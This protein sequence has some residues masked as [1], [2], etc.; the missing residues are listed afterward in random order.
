MLHEG[1]G[2]T[3]RFDELQRVGVQPGTLQPRLASP[4]LVARL[5]V[6]NQRATQV[7]ALLVLQ[8]DAAINAGN[9]GGPVFALDGS[10][11]GVAF[12]KAV[13]LALPT[14]TVCTVA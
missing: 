12:S 6:C 10:V 9:S 2:L 1:R 7:G 3:H 14:V 5:G 8:I 13:R 4:R 11:V